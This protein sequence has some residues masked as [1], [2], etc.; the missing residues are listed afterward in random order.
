MPTT[1]PIVGMAGQRY[2]QLIELMMSRPLLLTLRA[3][4]SF[5]FAKFDF[6]Q[7]NHLAGRKVTGAKLVAFLPAQCRPRGSATG[8]KDS[9][10]V[11]GHVRLD[12]VAAVVA[13]RALAL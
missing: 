9:R 13:V 5:D 11:E 10:P 1:K 3:C 2:G 6:N 4:E 8:V 12:W 7:I